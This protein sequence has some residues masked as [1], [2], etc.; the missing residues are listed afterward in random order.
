MVAMALTAC[1]VHML[2]RDTCRK[3]GAVRVDSQLGLE[4]TPEEYVANLVDVFRKVRRVLRD[5]GT[6]WLN[7]GDL[8]YGERGASR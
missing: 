6:V 7:L 4:A 2:Y 5:D 1:A 3:C 8:V